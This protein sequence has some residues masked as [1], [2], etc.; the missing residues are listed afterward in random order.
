MRFS[1]IISEAGSNAQ[2]AAIAIAMKKAGKKPKSVAEGSNKQLKEARK[3]AGVMTDPQ[4][5]TIK[6]PATSGF[7]PADDFFAKYPDENKQAWETAL[8]DLLDPAKA[9]AD[10][11]ASSA[12]YNKQFNDVSWMTPEEQA[13]YKQLQA[14]DQAATQ[15]TNTR[16]YGAERYLKKLF[17]QKMDAKKA[18]SML[19]VHW[20]PLNQLESFLQ[21][22]VNNKIELSA[23]LAPNTE[24]L[25]K[26]RWGGGSNPTVGIVLDGHITIGGRG[27]LASDQYK[28]TAGQRGQQK[29]SSRP[30]QIDPT[31]SMDTSVHHEVLVDNWKIKE[32]VLPADIPPE[33]D[34]LV[35]Q[36]KIP[37]R[38]LG[39]PQGVAEGSEDLNRQA[40]DVADK[41][42]TDKNLAKLNDMAHDST[43]YRALD[44]YFAKNNISTTIFNR[45]AAIV[46]KKLDDHGRRLSTDPRLQGVA[47][48]SSGLNKLH[49]ALWTVISEQTIDEENIN[50]ID[51]GTIAN[52]YSVFPTVTKIIVSNALDKARKE[53]KETSIMIDVMKKYAN[54][55]P[56]TPEE[57]EE[58]KYQFKDIVS[59]G[60]SALAGVLTA[61]VAGPAA[62]VGVA[63]AG[64]YK[65]E[66]LTL[67]QT[68]GPEVLIGLLKSKGKL[69]VVDILSAKLLGKH[70]L[71][72]YA[73][74]KLTTGSV[75]QGVA[76]GF[77]YDVDHMPGATVKNPNTSCK[78]CKGRG[79]LWKAP[80]G[81]I[82]PA[83]DVPGA[84]KYKC[85]ACDGIG[86]AKKEVDES[87]EFTDARMNAIKADKDT[88]V[89]H[90]KTYKVTGD[91][92]DEKEASF[93]EGENWSKH[94][95][96]RAGG[97]S[98]KSVSSYRRSHPG[99]K[100]Q[101][102]VTTKPSKLKKGSKAA[103]RRASFCAR[104]RGMKKHRTGAKTAHDPNSNINKSLRRWHCESIEE[105]HELVMLA[106]QYIRNN[107]K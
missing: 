73:P 31:L 41:L 71:P 63:L 22:K 32:I 68:K 91:T 54:N 13:Q 106:E 40:L 102:A 43:I 56:V 39:N 37:V 85:G 1:E 15:A 44:R 88:F 59:Y 90:G 97:M 46:F 70:A 62:G 26:K 48:D 35:Q 93:S 50:E 87:N 92:T 83:N 20:A 7:I 95:N 55:Q 69:D 10:A 75:N 78:R 42:T 66:L 36:Y 51:P 99:S 29:Y 103:K 58:M 84:K 57:N 24:S 60:L 52:L 72:F 80:D 98:K 3:I 61:T 96:K 76:E 64:A 74:A 100:I 17:Q 107:K 5:K 82:L 101:T 25:G 9:K 34:R 28:M 38:R 8:A 67:L 81:K 2:R 19:K 4:A 79:T 49:D 30:G 6:D 12:E 45:V 27:D 16:T 94:N 14:K 86:M 23:Y 77:P 105:L 11:A 21:G 65:K 89:V 33:V 104:M 18:A 47:E 53:A